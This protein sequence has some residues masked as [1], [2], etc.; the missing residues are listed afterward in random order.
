MTA[1]FCVWMP[2]SVFLTIAGFATGHSTEMW[3]QADT[4]RVGR[5]EEQQT[6]G[7]PKRT[8]ASEAKKT[9]DAAQADADAAKEVAAKRAASSKA[10]GEATDQA[11]KEHAAAWK[12]VAKLAEKVGKTKLEAQAAL[13]E[14]KAATK[15]SVEAQ[16]AASKAEAKL[17]SAVAAATAAASKHSEYKT[18]YLTVKAQQ[19]SLDAIAQQK[20]KEA[21]VIS[22]RDVPPTTLTTTTG[23]V[24]GKMPGSGYLLGTPTVLP[25]DQGPGAKQMGMPCAFPFIY[26]GVSYEDCTTVDTIN[27]YWCATANKQPDG[28]TAMGWGF[29]FPHK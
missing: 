20:A 15:K 16:D 2:L 3:E 21:D 24:S 29:C 14:E 28:K 8:A 12:N 5:E 7:D 11:T 13:E 23:Q 26:E 18:A 25:T 10:A 1:R 4:Q 22:A 27:E 6:V 19:D 17:Q 9:A